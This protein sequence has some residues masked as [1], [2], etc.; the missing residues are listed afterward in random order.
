[1][2]SDKAQ[3]LQASDIDL[4]IRLLR[5]QGYQVAAPT[6]REQAIVIDIIESGDELPRGW[7]DKQ[8]KGTYRLQRREDDAY[9]AYVVGPHSWKKYLHP[10]RQKIWDAEKQE[11]QIIIRQ[12]EMKE[13]A[14]AFLGVRSC[15]LHALK[16]QDRIFCEGSHADKRY[17]KRREKAF[18]IAVNCTHAAPTCFCTSMGTGPRVELDCDILLTEILTQ[19][20]HY[21]MLR[22]GSG[23]GKKLLKKL[24]LRVA[25]KTQRAREKELIDENAERIGQGPRSI[26]K[27]DHQE[28][29]Y[30]NYD[31]PHWDDV[32]RRC[33]S[34]ANCT[35]VCPTCFCS[36]VEDTTDL[37]GQHA[38]RWEHWDSCFNADFS[39]VHGG[40]VR[41]STASRYRQWLTHKLASWID[42]FGTS[43][44]VGC[45]RCVTWCPVGIDI[46]EEVEA[47]RLM[48]PAGGSHTSKQGKEV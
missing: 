22:A 39:F 5:E 43:G 25:K 9:F 21:F 1:M 4:L 23:A 19:G 31:S 28:L 14:M 3:I 20:E 27:D 35:M 6:I 8:E 36:D 13:P 11:Q 29:L 12:T 41:Q 38:E 26:T 10:P 32:A 7:S 42:Q 48:D 40:S 2:S 33:L 46:T 37:S 44:C 17:Q 16:I 15:D 47:I 30:R 18:I 45:G 24:P 34:C